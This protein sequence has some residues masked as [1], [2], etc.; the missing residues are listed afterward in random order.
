MRVFIFTLVLGLSGC[1]ISDPDRLSL[2]EFE[3]LQ[4]NA[5]HA[6]TNGDLHLA[7]ALWRQALVQRPSAYQMWCYLGQVS[8][9]QQRYNEAEQHYQ[10]CIEE[11]PSQPM[12]WRNLA[13]IQIRQATEFLLQAEHYDEGSPMPSATGHYQ[14][15]LSTLL[16]LQRVP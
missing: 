7:E 6:Y 11:N 15:L 9:R 1:A 16:E 12:M 5:E 3:H 10:K 14:Q 2:Q 4:R 13:A 8:F